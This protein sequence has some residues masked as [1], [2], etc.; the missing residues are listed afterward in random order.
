MVRTGEA[1]ATRTSA[2]KAD[3]ISP[4]DSL[5]QVKLRNG[6][7]YHLGDTVY[8]TPDFAGEP[9][10]V[11]R[12]LKFAL[13]KASNEY[14]CL[15]GH[16][17]RPKDVHVRH[18]RGDQRLLVA[19]MHSEVFA[20]EAIKGKCTVEHK[21]HAGKT[22]GELDAYRKREDCF[23]YDQ[24]YDRFTQRF[25]D[26]VPVELAKALPKE[27][28]LRLSNY[29]FILVENGKAADF[30]TAY[31]CAT[32]DTPAHLSESMLCMTCRHVYHMSCLDPP[33][34]KKPGKGFA[35][36][37]VDC[38][39]R[40]SAGLEY[41]EEGNKGKG[42]ENDINLD[43][44]EAFQVEG[45]RDQ[46]LGESM[47]VEGH[48]SRAVTSPLSKRTKK[49]L[50]PYR[51]FGEYNNYKAIL[52]EQLDDDTP[53]YP[54]ASSRIG[55][56]YQADL[57]EYTPKPSRRVELDNNGTGQ[58][59]DAGAG[60]VAMTPLLEVDGP[61]PMSIDNV[62]EAKPL[63]DVH[64]SPDV[65]MVDAPSINATGSMT[66]VSTP[67]IS[68]DRGETQDDTSTGRGTVSTDAKL[69]VQPEAAGFGRSRRGAGLLRKKSKEQG[70]MKL[71]KDTGEKEGEL[72]RS[73]EDERYF[74]L[75]EGFDGRLSDEYL[76]TCITHHAQL[77]HE[78]EVL[79]RGLE[80]LHKH[81]YDVS[82]ALARMLS[83]SAEELNVREWGPDE[84]KAFE[85]GI[86]KWGHDLHMVRK[87]MGKNR[88]KSRGDVVKFF[89][90][91]KKTR[92]YVPVYSQFCRKY[93]PSK[94][95]KS[96]TLDSSMSTDKDGNNSDSDAEGNTIHG[97][98]CTIC[99]T[100][101]GPWRKRMS[102][103]GKNEI[104]CVECHVWW[105]K[106]GGNRIVDKR[107]NREEGKQPQKRQPKKRPENEDE[108]ERVIPCAI[109]DAFEDYDGNS[110]V[111]CKGC[112]LRVHEECY[113]VDVEDDD[114][115]WQC[116]R[117]QSM[118]DA[119]VSKNYACILCPSTNKTDALKRTTWNN[120]IHL[121]CAI[122]F[123]E[124]RFVDV[125]AREPVES[126]ATIDRR[127][128]HQTCLLCNRNDGCC[129]TCNAKGCN[130]HFH[131]TCA[132]SNPKFS[133][134]IEES[135]SGR[136]V[137]SAYCPDHKPSPKPI[138][139]IVTPSL[140]ESSADSGVLNPLPLA[141][142][143]VPLT[144]SSLIS[145][146]I[147]DQKRLPRQLQGLAPI[148]RKAQIINVTDK[149]L[150]H[151]PPPVRGAGMNSGP[152]SNSTQQRTIQQNNV[153]V[154]PTRSCTGCGTHV[155]PYWWEEED[156]K[157]EDLE[158]PPAENGVGA[159]NAVSH[160]ME[161]DFTMTASTSAAKEGSSSG[162]GKL[163]QTCFHAR[164]NVVHAQGI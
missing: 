40:K 96:V 66:A 95:F 121:V 86:I 30:T 21:V 83:L 12:L 102:S 22:E 101:K 81:N 26:V 97:K 3:L 92:R 58:M 133:L 150:C 108:Q 82:S 41:A 65:Q 10:G 147:E 84:E 37:C 149:C 136:L 49:P 87:D 79:D 99:W 16:F 36:S 61:A 112:K 140:P 29:E 63:E 56:R 162:S 137:A 109:C 156:L 54:K 1:S 155:S 25:Y 39:R 134:L 154:A 51:Y 80:E 110:I 143:H 132:H 44:N 138:L 88:G 45:S 2:T 9:Y 42:K 27:V 15:V 148:Q 124:T 159:T 53:I 105:L 67:L 69:S 100:P 104:L 94:K 93:R 6:E 11:A 68:P 52:E 106:Y 144:K 47:D 130:R 76:S 71:D 59:D 4:L 78:T 5:A 91:W 85:A 116:S 35:W 64:L 125:N 24:F 32:C 129:L 111:T 131:A 128:A 118:T 57:P 72:E 153:R 48:T 103:G 122:W 163:C 157:A 18:G 145:M 158:S 14:V 33:L 62:D 74:S 60:A 7:V 46:L 23:Y 142:I 77:R 38:L 75:P 113:G 107:A 146:F 114:V 43:N 164:R 73:G 90:R 8:L 139:A 28:L 135:K 20:V 120:W 151:I 13:D 31:V 19:T 117:C 89:Y 119:E 123:P 161:V 115:N 70:K 126:V 50:W 127:K 55:K 34:T 160:E 141:P 17:Y 98:E 152:V